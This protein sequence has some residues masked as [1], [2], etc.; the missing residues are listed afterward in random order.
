M[1]GR[2]FGVV[3]DIHT[4][5]DGNLWLVGTSSGTVRKIRRL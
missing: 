4:G 2:D 3:T 1:W 5:A